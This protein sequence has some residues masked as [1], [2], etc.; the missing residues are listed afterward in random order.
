[1]AETRPEM[2]Q[3][4]PAEAT[5]ILPAFAEADLSRLD[6]TS[7]VTRGSTCAALP[8]SAAQDVSVRLRPFEDPPGTL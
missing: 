4:G 7:G 2:R 6:K 5:P 3:S 8:V 1:M